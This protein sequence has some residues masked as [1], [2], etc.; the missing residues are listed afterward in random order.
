MLKCALA[1]PFIRASEALSRSTFRFVNF[2][3]LQRTSLATLASRV[4]RL[5]ASFRRYGV[6]ERC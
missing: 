6:I 2:A 5:P 3:T 1:G 4:S